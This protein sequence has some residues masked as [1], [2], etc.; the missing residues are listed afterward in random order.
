MC[1]HQK[2]SVSWDRSLKGVVGII[3]TLQ[4][5]WV[6]NVWQAFGDDPC[7]GQACNQSECFVLLIDMRSHT[8]VLSTS[9]GAAS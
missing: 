3:L 4:L 2:L 7:L 9:A 6:S 5:H 1:P 8:D